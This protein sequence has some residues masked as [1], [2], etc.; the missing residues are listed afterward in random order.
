MT[1]REAIELKLIPAIRECERHPKRL[2]HAVTR[3]KGQ[4]LFPMD[5]EA[6]KRLSDK[7]IAI[8]DQMLFRFGRLQDA[9]G[10]RLLPA[11]RLAGQE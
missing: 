11:I 8:M 6:Y 2:H 4:G 9:I 7:E 5:A 3:G 1:P 10:Q